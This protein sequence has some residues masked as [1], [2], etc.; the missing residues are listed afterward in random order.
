MG[1]ILSPGFEYWDLLKA[2]PSLKQK[3]A[4]NQN[5]KTCTGHNCVQAPSPYWQR[6]PFLLSEGS[7][8]NKIIELKPDLSTEAE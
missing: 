1:C 3:T 7:A 6:S 5:F 8:G 2:S 4:E